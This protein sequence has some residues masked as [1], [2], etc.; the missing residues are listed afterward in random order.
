VQIGV[1]D[2]VNL[3]N[4]GVIAV[5]V[6]STADFDVAWVDV[7]GVRFAGAAAVQHAYED[8]NGDGLL[9]LVLHFRTQ[10][11]NLREIYEQLLADDINDDG[12]LDS[13]KQQAEVS[14][15]GQT[16][17]QIFI[18]GFDELSLFLSGKRLRDLLNDLASRGMI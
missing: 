14:L 1:R 8:V 16:V 9:D 13:G 11:T 3:Q 7:G 2:A 17:D 18:E 10:D 12:I 15:T 6:F 5:A 4:E